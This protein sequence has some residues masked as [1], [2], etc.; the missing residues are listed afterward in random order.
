VTRGKSMPGAC[1]GRT[2]FLVDDDADFLEMQRRILEHAGCTVASFRD[3]Q[4]ALAA[5]RAQGPGRT[6][7]LVVTDL[8]MGSLDAGFSLARAVKEEPGLAGVPVIV[9][10]AV[11]SQKGFDFR[12]R[13]AADL[14][15][16]NA[17]AWFDKP[18]DPAAF[19]AKVEELVR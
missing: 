5:L 9:V 4:A 3:P 7:A 14:S 19:L 13:S 1:G 11:A 16:M 10:S 17:D 2:V 18:V 12:P 6:P 15:A 8:M